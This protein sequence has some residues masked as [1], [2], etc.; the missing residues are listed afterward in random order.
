MTTPSFEVID[1][2]IEQA[3]SSIVYISDELWRLAELSLVEVKSAQLIIDH[4]QEHGFTITSKGTANVPTAFIAEWGS[5][6][7]VLG[8]LA[9]Y[10]ALPGLGNEPVSHREPRKDQTTSGHG[11]G[12]NL[13]GSATIGAA[14]ALKNLLD[15]WKIPGTIRVYGCPAEEAEGAKAYMARDGLFNDVDAALHWHP[16]SEARVINVRSLAVN[17]LLI[18]F[19]G[20]AAHA[21]VSPW[22]G[23]SAA[24]A[25]E[26]FAHAF[27]LMREHMEPNARL[28]YV[29]EKVGEAPNI[30]SDYARIRLYVRDTDHERVAATTIWVKQIAEAAALATQTSVKTLHYIGN[31][32]LLP[33]TPLA[34]RMQFHLARI[35]VP[36]YNSE[37]LE[38]AREIQNNNDVE[39]Q[40]MATTILPL[41]DD[42]TSFGGSTDVG[43]VSWSTPTMGCEMPTVPLGISMHTW[44]ATAC[45]GMGI[46]Q[47][48]AIQVARVL[49]ATGIDILTDAQLRQS[50]RADFEQR[51]GGKPFVSLLPPEVKRP[52]RLPEWMLTAP[53]L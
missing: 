30:I 25:A 40:G 11:C 21:G 1:Q 35:S 44:A 20:K 38:F 33:N 31:Y 32:D 26:I 29:F 13:I 51:T 42:T 3:R 28:H 47:K 43:D 41:P 48:G 22:L 2:A 5:G 6:T 18:E 24:H 37:E 17:K 27:N 4:L 53:V 10:D 34:E 50:A 7:P 49:A 8:L 9:E 52:T 14:L 12:H 39:P 36:S 45:H 15:T 46:G 19:F 16:G 23:R